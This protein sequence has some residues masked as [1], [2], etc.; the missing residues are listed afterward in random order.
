MENFRSPVT[1]TGRWIRLIPLERSHAPALRAAA[2]DPEVNRY[3]VPGTGTTLAEMEDLIALLLERQR[4]GT[5]LPFAVVLRTD[6]RP[7]GMTRF[8][9]IDRANDS[10]EVGGTWLPPVL[11]ETPV[12]AESKFLQFRYAFETANAHRVSLR[13]DLRDERSQ[14]AIVRF[15]ATREAVFREDTLLPDGSFRTTVAYGVLVSEWPRVRDRLESMLAHEGS[16][17]ELLGSLID[18]EASEAPER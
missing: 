8:L 3:L 6:G 1:L 14:R 12:H 2:R 15:G 11:S 17:P 4:T 18:E 9:A 5:E 16:P 10:V 13:A 7:V